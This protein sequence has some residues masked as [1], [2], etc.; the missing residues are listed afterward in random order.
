MIVDGLHSH[1]IGWIGL[2]Q[3]QQDCS[4]Y[5][6]RRGGDQR[7][8]PQRGTSAPSGS[9]RFTRKAFL[10]RAAQGL[11]GTPLEK[12]VPEDNGKFAVRGVLATARVA[13]GEVRVDGLAKLPRQGSAPA[14]EQVVSDFRAIHDF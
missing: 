5:G 8:G 3:K 13:S 10:D 6:E 7:K 14:V 4:G 12:A 11:G 9:W 1:R 2:P